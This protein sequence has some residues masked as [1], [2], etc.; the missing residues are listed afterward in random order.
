MALSRSLVH[1]IKQ[2]DYEIISITKKETVIVIG[3]SM[4]E[5]KRKEP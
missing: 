3:T 5:D 4:K 1:Q 2:A